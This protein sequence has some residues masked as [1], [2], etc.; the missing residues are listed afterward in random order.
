MFLGLQKIQ[1]S[2]KTSFNK[3]FDEIF[4]KSQLAKQG[5]FSLADGFV[6]HRKNW[7]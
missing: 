4:I 2:F 7:I 1:K 5:Q 6:E 3:I